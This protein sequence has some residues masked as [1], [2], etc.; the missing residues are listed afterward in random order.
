M[1]FCKNLRDFR[2]LCKVTNLIYKIINKNNFGAATGIRL[3][4]YDTLQ[5]LF[6]DLKHVLHSFWRRH[7]SCI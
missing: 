7:D 2:K 6:S 4:I 5:R 1:P 3:R